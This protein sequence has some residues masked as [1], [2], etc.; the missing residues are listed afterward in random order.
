MEKTLH[1]CVNEKEKLDAILEK[2]KCSLGKDGLDFNPLKKIYFQKPNLIFQM[3]NHK[4]HAF[5]II[6]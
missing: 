1:R 6:N 4:L 3:K 5:I 2:Q